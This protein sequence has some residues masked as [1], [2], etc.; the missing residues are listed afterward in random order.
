MSPYICFYTTSSNLT[1]SFFKTLWDRAWFSWPILQMKTWETE[2]F[3]NLPWSLSLEEED[4]DLNWKPL[5]PCLISFHQ[6]ELTDYSTERAWLKVLHYLCSM[7]WLKISC[8]G[9][10]KISAFH[11]HKRGIRILFSTVE[12]CRTCS[13]STV[14]QCPL[15][16]HL[17]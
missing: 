6:R 2:R 12:L 3:K 17:Y 5:T 9:L 7:S 11:W 14:Q 4:F 10:F 16:H 15:R 8:L 1:I 13:N